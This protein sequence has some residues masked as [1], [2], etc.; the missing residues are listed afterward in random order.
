M[1]RIIKKLQS[2]ISVFIKKQFFGNNRDPW[3]QTFKVSHL[4]K[5]SYPTV[6]YCEW[7]LFD[8]SLWNYLMF[9]IEVASWRKWDRDCWLGLLYNKF[10]HQ[11]SLIEFFFFSFPTGSFKTSSHPWSIFI[12]GLW[13]P[14]QLKESRKKNWQPAE[15]LTA[16]NSVRIISPLK[17]F[18]GKWFRLSS[19]GKSMRYLPKI[20][21][22]FTVEGYIGMILEWCI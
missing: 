21:V 22:D 12:L 15:K 10:T 17:A 19:K 8:S 4:K 6:W 3:Q 5:F 14:E 18:T 13:K 1:H 20:F 16:P 7:K 9:R 11:A 2:Q